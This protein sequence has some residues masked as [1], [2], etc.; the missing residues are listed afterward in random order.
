MQSVRLKIKPLQTW[1]QPFRKKKNLFLN[2]ITVQSV[3][4]ADLLF[5]WK[6]GY[7]L[8][9]PHLKLS[10]CLILNDFLSI[11]FLWQQWCRVSNF[12]LVNYKASFQAVYYFLNLLSIKKVGE[13]I[14]HFPTAFFFFFSLIFPFYW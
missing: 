2:F 13:K 14:V 4:C 8:L 3:H 1:I 11:S 12:L 10:K 7:I 6:C 9:L 5:T